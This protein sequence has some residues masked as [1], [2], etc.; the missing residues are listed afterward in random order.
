MSPDRPYG[1]GMQISRHWRLNSF[2][3]QLQG[4]RYENG[5]VRLT[6]RPVIPQRT[7][8]PKLVTSSSR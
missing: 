2:R 7:E 6:A 8:K 3:Y 5:Q 4:V 1:R